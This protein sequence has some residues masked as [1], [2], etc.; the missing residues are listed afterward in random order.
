MATLLKHYF[1]KTRSSHLLPPKV[2]LWFE[3]FM[4]G[5]WTNI[6]K[7]CER[8]VRVYKKICVIV[9]IWGTIVHG[10]LILFEFCS[11]KINCSIKKSFTSKNNFVIWCPLAWV[12]QIY[13]KQFYLM[14]NKKWEDLYI[15]LTYPT[16]TLHFVNGWTD[17]KSLRFSFE[18][19]LLQ[20]GVHF[21]VFW[22]FLKYMVKVL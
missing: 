5:I 11:T 21:Q 14:T 4:H 2:I 12:M 20:D 8:F 9:N 22:N 18:H 1:N 19:I 15:S 3:F 6:I 10:R 16:S 13:V 7:D 17:I